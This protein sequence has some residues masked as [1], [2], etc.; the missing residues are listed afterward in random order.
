MTI[1]FDE[2][3]VWYHQ[4][5]QD[6]AVLDGKERL[7]GRAAA[8]GRHLQFRGRAAGRLH[9]QHIHPP[10]GRGED[11]LHRAAG[12]RHRADHDEPGGAAWKQTIYYPY[13]FASLY[14]R[15]TALNLAVESPGYD[16]DIA[17]TCPISIFRVCTTKRA[18]PPTFF[19]VNRNGSDALELSVDLK[20]FGTPQVIAHQVIEGAD[21]RQVNGLANQNAVG[22]KA[23]TGLSVDGNTL[24]GRVGP[25]S[26][27]MIRVKLS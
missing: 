8:A 17:E 3:N 21:L 14:G 4:R 25:H 9:P 11:R 1:S 15:G 12:E 26:Y 16:A 19:A 27:H 5:A 18:R 6:R 24:T 22:P 20:G 10:L 23:G 7:A 2:W 13:Y